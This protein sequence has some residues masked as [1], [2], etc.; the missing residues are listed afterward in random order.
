MCSDLARSIIR[1]LVTTD[2]SIPPSGCW[3]AVGLSELECL[4]AL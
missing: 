3:L 4:A 1:E 2:V